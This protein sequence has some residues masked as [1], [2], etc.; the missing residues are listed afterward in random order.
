MALAFILK[1]L[2]PLEM[3]K[4]PNKAQPPCSPALEA[5]LGNVAR[6]KGQ[7]NTEK[8]T[9]WIFKAH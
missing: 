2:T 4:Y 8:D 3:L 6:M 9:L 7:R 1:C 5:C